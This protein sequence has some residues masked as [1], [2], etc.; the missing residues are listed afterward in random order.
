MPAAKWIVLALALFQGAW[1]TFDGGRALIVGDYVTPKSGSRAG[2]LGPWSQIVSALG[3]NPRGGF[4]KGV[5]VLLG[6]A[7][8]AA[9]VLLFIR[10]GTGRCFAL[11]CG[12]A[13]LW[14]L[15]IGTVVSLIVIGLMLMS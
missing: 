10:S 14:Y 5:H 1:L 15:P 12:V 13:T 9:V 4:M 6:I 8:L 2:Q 11:G 3:I 7:W